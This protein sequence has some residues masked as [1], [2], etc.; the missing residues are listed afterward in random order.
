MSVAYVDTSALLAIAFSERGGT[1]LAR[2]LKAFDQLLSSNLL[3]AELR[4]AFMRE[5]VSDAGD[6]LA[7][8]A[9]ILPNRAL[10]SEIEEVLRAGYLKG[11]DLW[12]VACAL[13][14]AES[15]E[16]MS[17]VSLDDRQRDVANVLG[18][19]ILK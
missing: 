17:F 1:T 9:W 6:L 2:Q 7:G 10:S 19:A 14:I 18:F 15:P 16:E 13:F 8:F 3:E 5:G 11:A 12:H 4:A